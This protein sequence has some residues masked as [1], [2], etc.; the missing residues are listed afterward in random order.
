MSDNVSYAEMERRLADTLKYKAAHHGHLPL[1]SK[2]IKIR[3]AADI[4]KS[5][6]LGSIEQCLVIPGSHQSR[7][8]PSAKQ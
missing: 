2:S 8:K 5:K 1:S 3:F 6:A 7:I 4:S